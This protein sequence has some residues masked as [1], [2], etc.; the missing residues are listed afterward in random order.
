MFILT[1]NYHRFSG[2]KQ[3]ILIF[4]AFRSEV[5]AGFAGFF[6]QSQKTKIKVW[7]EMCCYLE[8]MGNSFLPR[9]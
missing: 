5:P 2:F 8:G 9:P 1:F 6:V 7:A 4:S 3:Y